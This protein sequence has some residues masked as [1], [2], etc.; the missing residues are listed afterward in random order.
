ML[1]FIATELAGRTS[2]PATSC[3]LEVHLKGMR[4]LE[5][6]PLIQNGRSRPSLLSL[7][8]LRE[9]RDIILSGCLINYYN[10]ES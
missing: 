4:R 9:E 7:P 2:S 3:I 1:P 10:A 6:H 8:N 5:R